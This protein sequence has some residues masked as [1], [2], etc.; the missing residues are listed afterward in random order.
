M[1]EA[2]EPKAQLEAVP[3]DCKVRDGFI[4][5]SDKWPGYSEEVLFLLVDGTQSIGASGD[6][7]V[8]F[9]EWGGKCEP[10]ASVV[11]WKSLTPNNISQSN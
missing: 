11:A 6:N 8:Y 7:G 2:N 3:L 10:H 9:V 5:V 4:P 1:S